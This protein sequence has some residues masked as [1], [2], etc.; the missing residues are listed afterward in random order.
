MGPSVRPR[1]SNIVT[2]LY[3]RLLPVQVSMVAMGSINSIV[4]GVIAGRFIDASTV[5]V[6]GLYYT[7]LRILGAG[8]G[9]SPGVLGILPGADAALF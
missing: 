3:M 5:G 2:K 8:S 9:N 6:V 4:D 7:V 1:E